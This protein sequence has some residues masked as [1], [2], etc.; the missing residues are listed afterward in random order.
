M[1]S[2]TEIYAPF[3]PAYL[4]GAVGEIEAIIDEIEVLCPGAFSRTKAGEGATVIA[5]RGLK[6]G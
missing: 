6:S 4:A 5:M 3:D 1:D 2:T